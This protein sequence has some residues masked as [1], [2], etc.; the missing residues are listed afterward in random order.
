MTRLDEIL[1]VL[2]VLELLELLE[3]QQA[4]IIRLLSQPLPPYFRLESTPA[5]P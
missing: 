3:A 1:E 5:Q 4:E 2:E